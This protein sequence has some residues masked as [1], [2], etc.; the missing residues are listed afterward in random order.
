MY[1]FISIN[2]DGFNAVK[3]DLT[4]TIL[5]ANAQNNQCY[6]QLSYITLTLFIW[7]HMIQF[8]ELKTV[9]YIICDF[10][11]L[12]LL[13]YLY[14]HIVIQLCSI[15]MVHVLVTMLITVKHYIQHKY[16][17]CAQIQYESINII[18]S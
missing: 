11:L 16:L 2:K 12:L 3:R 15:K 6:G 7:M 1:T 17:I 13:L 5:E 18:T 14:S 8:V 9:L 4:D 10:I